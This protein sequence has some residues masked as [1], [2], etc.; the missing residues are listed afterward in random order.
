MRAPHTASRFLR[1]P[2]VR[3]DLRKA[4]GAARR[5][6]PLHIC[7]LA[8]GMSRRKP[9]D[10]GRVN[11]T[12]TFRTS[13]D[14]SLIHYALNLKRKKEN[15]PPPIPPDQKV[16]KHLII[17][18]TR[19]ASKNETTLSCTYIASTTDMFR[20]FSRSALKEVTNYV[21]R[22]RTPRTSCRRHRR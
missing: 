7:L 22:P 17:N 10:R 19:R 1:A 18:H 14:T 5:A 6:L 9:A 4:T 2:A 20:S 3:G 11:T 16:Y 21:M 13:R 8:M 12:G 15:F